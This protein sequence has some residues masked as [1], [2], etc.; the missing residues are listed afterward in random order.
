MLESHSDLMAGFAS[1]IILG[2]NTASQDA[3]TA[4]PTAKEIFDWV[5][6]PDAI[7]PCFVKDVFEARSE[8]NK[9]E[10]DAH[11]LVTI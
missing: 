1:S 9:G 10:R 4:E 2:Q 5:M 7:A 8:D 3:N 6:T 11:L